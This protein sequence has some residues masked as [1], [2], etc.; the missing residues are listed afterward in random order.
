MRKILNA[1]CVLLCIFTALTALASCKGPGKG[2]TTAVTT[3]DNKP[4]EG[5]AIDKSSLV[6]AVGQTQK[7]TTTMHHLS[8][9]SPK[10]T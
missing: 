6:L 9:L 7:L 5:I 2:E 8:L 10:G 1:A 3:G 4:K